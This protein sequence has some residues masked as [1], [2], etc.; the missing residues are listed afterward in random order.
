[1][2]ESTPPSTPV[3][4]SRFPDIFVGFSYPF[5][6]IYLLLGSPKLWKYALLPFA[7]NLLAMTGLL[8]L[9]IGNW[10]AIVDYFTPERTAWYLHVLYWIVYVLAI[11]VVTIAFIFLSTFL[12]TLIASPFNDLLVRHTLRIL[13]GA[14]APELPFTARIIAQ[15]VWRAVRHAGLTLLT[16]ALVQALLL[17]VNFLLPVVGTVIY[18]ILSNLATSLFQ[19]EL[20]LDPAMGVFRWG[21]RRKWG[22]LLDHKWPLVGFGLTTT[23]VPCLNYLFMPVWVV[24]ATMAF[25][26]YHPYDPKDAESVRGALDPAPSLPAPSAPGG[27]S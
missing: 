19:A 1:M 26:V 4:A 11:L 9:T 5:R 6:G 13:D 25:R 24:S 16:W 22:F 12:G 18:L 20:L 23:L 8:W 10:D 2:P 17:A 15:D 27:S 3:R 14:E 21:W 7:I